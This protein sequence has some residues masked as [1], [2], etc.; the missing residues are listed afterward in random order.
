MDKA[1]KAPILIQG[2]EPYEDQWCSL[3]GLHYRVARLGELSKDFPV[4]EIPLR[5]LNIYH[6]YHK[7]TLRQMVAHMRAVESADLDYPI[8]LDE[9]GEVLDGR[10]RIMKAILL[11]K[12]TI[13]AVRFDTNPEPDKVEED[14]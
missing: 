4:M 5:H 6:V 2:T 10:H 9:D 11:N 3:G 1:A 13:K 8:I 12:Q 7:L 14:D